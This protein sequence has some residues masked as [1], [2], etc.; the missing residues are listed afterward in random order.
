M[1][2]RLMNFLDKSRSAFNAVRNIKDILVENKYLELR[3]NEEFKLEKGGKYFIVRNNS[4]ILAFNIGKNVTK[5][6]LHL[7]A[8][9]SDCPSFKLKPNAIIKTEAGVKLNVEP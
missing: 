5:P 6:S 4:S 7:C 1:I 8:S 2:N 3:E 9:H